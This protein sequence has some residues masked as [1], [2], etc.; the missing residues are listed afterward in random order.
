[1]ILGLY[2]LFVDVIYQLCIFVLGKLPRKIIDRKYLLISL[3]IY[4]VNNHTTTSNLKNQEKEVAFD[5]IEKDI[6]QSDSI[7]LR[8]FI[9]L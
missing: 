4:L 3:Y 2:L 5:N 1:M 6:D 7:L 9:N 8:L